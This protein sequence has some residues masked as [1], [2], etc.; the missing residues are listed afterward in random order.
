[1]SPSLRLALA[2]SVL[3]VSTAQAVDLTKPARR[4]DITPIVVPEN[5]RCE[6]GFATSTF[7]RRM[8][9]Q[10]EIVGYQGCYE[11][12]DFPGTPFALTPWGF[13]A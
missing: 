3:A 6:P 8:N 5:P 13:A 9:E 2:A 4:Y 7:T 10:G 12:S 1:M 11:P